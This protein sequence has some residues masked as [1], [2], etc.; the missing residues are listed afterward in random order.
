[1]ASMRRFHLAI[2]ERGDFEFSGDRLRDS[3]QFT[4]SIEP[5]DEIAEGIESHAPRVPKHS[6]HAT[7]PAG[8]GL[9][10][11]H[12]QCVEIPRARVKLAQRSVGKP[13]KEAMAPSVLKRFQKRVESKNGF[14]RVRGLL[15]KQ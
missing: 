10:D 5:F 13:G 3:D 12:A 4:G 2:G 14:S 8:D 1:F 6:L 9:R 11:S 7:F 15:P